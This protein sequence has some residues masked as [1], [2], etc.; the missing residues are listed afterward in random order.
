M[1]YPILLMSVAMFLL[2]GCKK[3]SEQT[4][5]TDNGYITF[6]LECNGVGGD[7]VDCYVFCQDDETMCWPRGID[8][9]ILYCTA[10]EGEPSEHG[11]YQGCDIN[12]KYSTAT[13]NIRGLRSG[14]KYKACAAL[15]YQ[16]GERRFS[17]TIE[18]TTH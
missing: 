16:Q 1:K 12:E 13:A 11:T 10:E 8:C 15:N 3:E 17:N 14:T 9:G 6:F 7:W 5:N 4:T 18:F 2:T